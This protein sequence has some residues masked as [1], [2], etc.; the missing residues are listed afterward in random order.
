MFSFS[1]SPKCVLYEVHICKIRFTGNKTRNHLLFISIANRLRGCCFRIQ[2]N[3]INKHLGISASHRR[4]YSSV[5][6]FTC[7]SRYIVWRILFSFTP[8]PKRGRHHVASHCSICVP[9]EPSKAELPLYKI[10][11]CNMIESKWDSTDFEC[12]TCTDVGW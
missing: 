9:A 8:S 11:L 4:A 7:V 2:P 6:Y 3:G 1:I 10:T 5:Y 12:K